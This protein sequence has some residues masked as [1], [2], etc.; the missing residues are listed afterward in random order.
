[1]IGQAESSS[2]GPYL[3]RKYILSL[4]LACLLCGLVAVDLP[5]GAGEPRISKY[6]DI[7]GVTGDEVAAIE[8]LKK[9]YGGFTLAML[10]STESFHRDD[11]S[12]GGFSSLFC[13]WLSG[14]FGV[15]FKPDIVEWNTLVDGFASGEIDFSGDLTATPESREIYH[16]TDAVAERFV[17]Y[18]RLAGSED[19]PELAARRTLRFAFLKGSRIV[20]DVSKTVD[21]PFVATYV[22][23]YGEAADLLRNRAVDAFFAGSHA[24]AAFEAYGDITATEYFPLIYLPVSLS[25]GKSELAP[26]ISVVQKYL[27]QDDV[28]YSL[29]ELYDQGEDEYRKHKFFMQ[30]NEEE[31]NYLRAHGGG[32][33]I[34][35]AVE[36][37]NYPFSFYNTAERQW[38]G[39]ALDVLREISDL[40][41]LS[42]IIANAP[43][44]VWSELLSALEEGK[45]A[46]I[47]ELIPTRDRQGRFLWVDTPYSTDNFALISRLEHEYIKVNRILH[48]TVAVATGTAY[49]EVFNRR[50]PKHRRIVRFD[51][52]DK[53]FT[54]LE[55]GEVDFVMASRYRMQ[56]MT[57]QS[58][59]SRFKVN[60]LFD[61]SHLSS[62]GLNINE[63]VLCSIISK[64]QKTVDTKG[65]AD[66]WLYRLFDYDA[67]RARV[68]QPY[69]IGLSVTLVAI[70]AL[71]LTLL[72]RNRRFIRELAAQAEI[73]RD[74]SQ[75]KSEFLSRMS[76]EIRTPMN[77]VVG[78]AEVLLRRDL[79][80]E[81]ADEVRHLKQAGISLLAL[82]N[83]ILDFSKIEAGKMDIANEEYAFSALIRSV[84]DIIRFR[85][86]DK[87]VAFSTRIDAA[88]PDRLRGDVNR[89]RQILLNL[90]SN[91]VKYTRQGSVIFTVSGAMQEDGRLRL[92]FEVADTGIGIRQ[93]DMAELFKS[94]KRVD[95]HK[96]MNIEGTGLG[97]TIAGSLCRAMGGDI[98]ASSEY[99]K[100]S[101]F[102]AVLTQAVA[103]WGTPA[104]PADALTRADLPRVGFTAPEADVLVVDDLPSNLL[105]AEGLLAPYKMRVYTCLVGRE[106]VELVRARPF[107]LVLMDHMM[108]EM[109]GVEVTRAIRDMDEER[110]RT[111]P[112]VVLTANVVSGM[113]EMFLK[114][115]FSDFLS[116]PI[117]TLK[118]DAVLRQWL[119]P[120]KRRGALGDASGRASGPAGPAPEY[121][122][123]EGP[124]SSLVQPG[125][126]LPVIAGLDVGIGVARVGG[127]HNLYL[128]LLA[129][130]R[131]D[132]EA[133]LARIAEDPDETSLQAFITQV[134]A[135]KSAL[136]NI[137][138]EELSREAALLEKAGNEADMPLIREKLPAFREELASLA[139]RIGAA[140]APDS[141][142]AADEG[143][144]IA[145]AVDEYLEQL[146]TALE[147]LDAGAMDAALARL[148]ALPLPV[149]LRVIVDETAM[150]ILTAEFEKAAAS[151]ASLLERKY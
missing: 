49:E 64:A 75:A 102:T 22:D 42:F 18:F 94:F 120:G 45:V 4:L 129:V 68:R 85:I 39:I 2:E 34:P 26:V 106:A 20:H 12:I 50:F 138:A 112:I 61:D 79:P 144:D 10:H 66:Q 124:A 108:P 86:A 110:C 80:A 103:D 117:N 145:P 13:A 11:G 58:G 59:K 134:H 65:I 111:M 3:S 114:N 133:C 150:Y 73:A 135:A 62:F 95:I 67:E 104:I 8:A 27:N 83:D 89:V 21:A 25:T 115:G 38:Q 37:D 91:A 82:I 116:K 46:L 54:A 47:S 88:L 143:R 6:T 90:L 140:S 69:L 128:E 23:Y 136:A 71:L 63:T 1:M 35:I 32:R 29:A 107:D 113:K 40:S 19:L 17:K 7:P 14:L 137:G 48:S 139:A 93:E 130:F 125:S 30:L 149:K 41:G 109:D 15:P 57:S 55:K 97:L 99:G 121:E 151:V 72:R 87:P 5:A 146:R 74:A 78:L 33:N 118:L 132:A 51:S 44:A 127:S 96:N 16:M 9:R 122:R 31:K 60:V 105:V 98:T 142:P 141:E 148:Q 131:V 123:G 126:R 70:A 100:G 77:V 119:P 43:D 28:F 24:E 76:H 147:T 52:T 56:S 84:E 53:C 81:A 36:Y 101:V 92:S